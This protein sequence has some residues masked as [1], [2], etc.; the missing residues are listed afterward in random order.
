VLHYYEALQDAAYE[1]GHDERALQARSLMEIVCR[2]RPNGRLLDIGAG[3]GIL[4]EEA[5]KLGFEAEGIEPSRW[6]CERAQNSGHRVYCGVFPH[7]QA[8]GPYDVVTLVD[9]IEHV[10][11]PLGLLRQI[12]AALRPNGILLIVTPDVRSIAARVMGWR[13][14]HFRVA[15]IGYFDR[16]TLSVAA[17]AAGF[18][19]EALGRPTWFFRAEYL[20]ER[21]Q[22]YLPAFLRWNA[23][24]VVGQL[25]I[26]LN[27]RD[28][29]WA[30]CR[31]YGDNA[32]RPGED[33]SATGFE[34]DRI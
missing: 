20:I 21:I 16:N 5:S 18:V 4:V 7:P 3:I 15:H 8:I 32:G 13:W 19:I 24:R 33:L 27:L 26:P 28:S 25:V 12:R 23:A 2:F 30:V 6:L 1:Q 31:P 34:C 22:K 14:W 10:P 29:L 11:D 9:V 17:R